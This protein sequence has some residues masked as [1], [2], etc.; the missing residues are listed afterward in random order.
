MKMISKAEVKK[1]ILAMEVQRA[2]FRPDAAQRAK[3]Q[4]SRRASEK[5]VSDFLRESGLDMKKFEALQ[6]QRGIERERIVAKDKAE[7]LR[8]A[9]KLRDT[10][11]SGIFEQSKALAELAS[12]NDFFPYPTFTLDTPYL[13]WTTPLLDLYQVRVRP[14][15][16]WARFKFS[17]SRYHG[18]QRVGFYFYW[19]NP[20]QDYALINVATF[21]SANG[22][23][24]S[25]APW[26]FGVNSS[27][28]KATAQLNMWL[29]GSSALASTYASE[30]L[31]TTRAISFITTF[32]DTN[33][34]SISSGASLNATM[35]AVPPSKAVMLEVALALEYENDEGD[36][37]ADFK[38]DSFKIACPVV[39]IS[40]LNSL[41]PV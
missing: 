17:T 25:N 15:D 20:F 9:P 12:R 24:K 41:A 7:A 2:G 19:T 1:A 36:I 11:H 33:G 16:S 32:G 3:M 34:T 13:I 18:T 35:F 5:M 28:V 4:K 30:F 6:R 23:L 10:P 22:Y 26:T 40:L 31:G 37:E 29:S 27:S 39:V 14:F 8:R 21:M 38:T